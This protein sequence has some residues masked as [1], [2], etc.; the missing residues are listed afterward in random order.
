MPP[1]NSIS[2][3]TTSTTTTAA[4]W[5]DVL[6]I[7]PAADLFPRVNPDELRA[8][9]DDIKVHG[10]RTPPVLY[11]AGVFGC[12]P[13]TEGSLS[14]LDGITRFNALELNGH[15]PSLGRLPDT[16]S[17][18]YTIDIR[19][20]ETHDVLIENAKVGDST[21]DP[22]EYVTSA[23]I[24]RRHLTAEQKREL[25]GELL[26]AMP[27]KSDRV[28]AGMIKA[29]PTTVG[30][31]RTEM[32]ATVQSGQLPEKR[33]GKDGKT[34]KQQARKMG[35]ELSVD[36]KPIVRLSRVKKLQQ[37]NAALQEEIDR[38]DRVGNDFFNRNDT[39]P[40]ICRVVAY[41]LLRLSQSKRKTVLDELPEMVARLE[42][43]RENGISRTELP[44]EQKRGRHRRTIEDFQH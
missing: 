12:D 40:D 25:I 23:N 13:I 32:K 34:R 26:K 20:V 14:L 15:H 4:S 27:E 24:H 6:P 19:D 7:H 30:T 29:S 22:P 17:H 3:A 31:V 9:A 8:L 21:T 28:I 35:S 38:R 43:E 5:H 36:G 41:H 10:V 11:F 39:A 44:R 16:R 42:A 1:P 37:V 18:N 2:T 33:I